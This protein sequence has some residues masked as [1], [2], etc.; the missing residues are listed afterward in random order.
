MSFFEITE[1]RGH[2]IQRISVLTPSEIEKLEANGYRVIRRAI[3]TVLWRWL[4]GD[5]DVAS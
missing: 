4:L 2:V 1:S 3:D 5:E